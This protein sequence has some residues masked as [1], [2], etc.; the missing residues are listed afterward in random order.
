MHIIRT[1]AVLIRTQTLSAEFGAGA[2]EI[3]MMRFIK[4]KSCHKITTA[5]SLLA[6]GDFRE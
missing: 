2:A 6:I 3:S 1:K 4:Q 5:S